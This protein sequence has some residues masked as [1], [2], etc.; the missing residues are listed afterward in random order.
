MGSGHVWDIGCDHGLLGLSFSQESATS[1]TLVD[2][3]PAVIEKLKIKINSNTSHITK[4]NISIMLSKGQDLKLSNRNN[5][6]FIAGMGGEEIGQIVTALLP[7]LDQTSRIVIS[8]HR[9]GLELRKLLASLELSIAHEEVV[10][11]DGQFYPILVLHP[12]SGPKVHPYGQKIW[13]GETGEAY[14]QQQL[15]HFQVH[16]D[17]ASCAYVSYLRALKSL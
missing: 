2:P 1:I 14:R 3:S 8:P 15:L 10:T 13:E 4:P 11:E 16:R 6:I 17:E 9:K 5:T 12:G 7:Q